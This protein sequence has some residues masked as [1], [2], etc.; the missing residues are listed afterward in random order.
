MNE[1]VYY[2]LVNGIRTWPGDDRNWTKRAV[3]WLHGFEFDNDHITL[4]AECIEYHTYAFRRWRNHSDHVQ[5]FG[6]NLDHHRKWKRVRIVA[7]SNGANIV[8]DA[9]RDKGWPEIEHLHLISPACERDIGYLVP[10]LG[11]TIKHM[12][13]WQGVQ[14]MP[15]RLGDMWSNTKFP[16]LWPGRWLGYGS[17]GLNTPQGLTPEAMEHVTIHREVTFG[18]STWFSARFFNQTMRRIIA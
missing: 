13:I 8:L 10:Q 7:H 15:L 16:W 5:K 4:A 3:T 9:L 14:D 1:P 6:R 12:T 11:N 18:H 2:A 17:L